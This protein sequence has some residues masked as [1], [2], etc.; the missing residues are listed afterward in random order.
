MSLNRRSNSISDFGKS[1]V[2]VKAVMV[3]SFAVFEAIITAAFDRYGHTAKEIFVTWALCIT[4]KEF[5]T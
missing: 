4:A 3:A 1:S 5:D 2:T